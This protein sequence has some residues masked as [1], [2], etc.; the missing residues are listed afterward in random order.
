MTFSM[1][2]TIEADLDRKVI[3]EK[4]YG[5]WK[6]DTARSYHEEFVKVATPLTGGK[7]AKLIDL[8]NWRSSYPEVVDIV[9]EHL[10]W[11]RENGMILSVNI[12]E[13]PVTHGQLKRMFLIGGTAGMS[14]I[15]KSAQDGDKFLKESGF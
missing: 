14:K 6:E 7:W 13:N 11:C 12:I 5:I 15:F 1:N 2:F 10:V 9:G 8:N 4:I 3:K